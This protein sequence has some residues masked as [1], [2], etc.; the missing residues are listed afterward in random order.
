MGRKPRFG[1]L[2]SNLNSIYS[3]A[4]D[5][6]KG[7]AYI[8]A[9]LGT[10]A[11]TFLI[12]FGFF[13]RKKANVYSKQVNYTVKSVEKIISKS[14][15]GKPLTNPGDA[16][17]I[18][19]YKLTGTVVECSNNIITVNYPSEVA[20]GQV[21][22]VWMRDNCIGSDAVATSISNQTIG[23][24]MMG[25]GFAIILFSMISIY[26]VRRYKM[27]AAAHGVGSVFDILS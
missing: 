9:I 24:V 12:I 4:A 3:G 8:K 27:A 1:D 22:K 25:I 16:K 2:N 14:G 6:G 17:P 26:I 19:Y 11:G 5:F 7:M 21:V 15:D 23:Y 20:V 10:I 18:T 13:V